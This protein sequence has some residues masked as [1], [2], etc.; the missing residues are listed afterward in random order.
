MI[1]TC[2]D[3]LYLRKLFAKDGAS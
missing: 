3:T 2:N 1:L